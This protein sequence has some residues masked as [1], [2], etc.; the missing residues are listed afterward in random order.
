MAVET[1]YRFPNGINAVQMRKA[2]NATWIYMKEKGLR[3]EYS[4]SKYS[5]TWNIVDEPYQTNPL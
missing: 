3:H 2:L 5:S 4:I 1:L